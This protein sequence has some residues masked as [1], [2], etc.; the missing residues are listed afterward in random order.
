MS[1][2]QIFI[3][4]TDYNNTFNVPFHKNYSPARPTIS[5]STGPKYFCVNASTKHSTSSGGQ[6]IKFKREVWELAHKKSSR[7]CTFSPRKGIRRA[8]M[9]E[10]GRGRGWQGRAA[11]SAVT[12]AWRTVSHECWRVPQT[13]EAEEGE[14][15]Q[16]EWK[17][18]EDERGF[19]LSRR[20]PCGWS[21]S[22]HLLR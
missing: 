12:R 15:A 6:R 19:L 20:R 21:D 5:R 8:A 17:S 18:G 1:H 11:A 9:G 14:C 22:C 4:L 16:S 7:R 10:K 13:P 2:F 3:A